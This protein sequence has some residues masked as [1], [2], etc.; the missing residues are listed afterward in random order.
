M[1]S[2]SLPSYSLQIREQVG[3][4][5][6]N[7][8]F[9]WPAGTLV[10]RRI[11]PAWINGGGKPRRGRPPEGV[12]DQ[13]GAHDRAR[14]IIAEHIAEAERQPAITF[15]DVALAWL[16]RLARRG[17][18]PSTM[19]DHRS[20]LS[21][22]G[23]GNGRVMAAL[24]DLPAAGITTAEVA[25]MLDE[26]ADSGASPRTVN[27]YRAVV[28]AVFNFGVRTFE[29][30]GNPVAATDKLTEPQREL[31]T[32]TVAEVEQLADALAA[33]LHRDPAQP[34]VKDEEI[35]ARRAEDQQDAEI[36]R[37]AAYT[38][39]RLG[40]LLTLRWGDIGERVITVSRSLSA[41]KETS[42]K[43][44]RVRHVAIAAP[45]REAFDRLRERGEFVGAS[46]YVFVNRWLGQ[47]IDDSALR[48]RYRRAQKAAGVRP[49]RFHDLRHTFGSLLA[50]A[51]VPVVE[52]QA[53][54]GHSTI[55][56]TQ[57]YMH[58]RQ[59][60]ELVDRFTDALT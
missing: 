10:K 41:G 53:A 34:A 49:L 17:V 24:G 6:Y 21:E 30:P 56:T 1:P 28:G 5:V 8:V 40:E 3:G 45:A 29:L 14:E 38:G 25:S 60:S 31:N 51:G 52:I 47:R 19:R 35:A 36:V 39:L 42:T 37:V 33:G 13:A 18:K 7:V 16:D 46:D 15:R 26:L 48:K 59:A 58:S 2:P 27:K 54:M 44:G 12:F 55:T 20:I 32:Y 4:S 50:Q 57:R 43:S 23:G 9:R 22:P 11:G